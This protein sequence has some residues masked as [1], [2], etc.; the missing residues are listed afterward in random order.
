M[1]D[2]RITIANTDGLLTGDRQIRTLLFVSAVASAGGENQ[3]GSQGPGRSMG[4]EMFDTIDP[5]QVG[6]DAARQ[7]VTMLHAGYCPAGRMTVAIENG[8]GGVIF[9]EACGHSLEATS[10]AK[11]RS[12]FAGKLGQQNCQRQG[13]R[14]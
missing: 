2:R 1:W 12:Q 14:H 10:V 8:F 13:N 3:S 6:Q 4:L 9:H 7:A 5:R 11:G